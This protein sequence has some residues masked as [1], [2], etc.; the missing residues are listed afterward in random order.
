MVHIGRHIIDPQTGLCEIC[1]RG[2]IHQFRQSK[3]GKQFLYSNQDGKFT[4]RPND[5]EIYH[6]DET[7]RHVRKPLYPEP[8]PPRPRPVVHEPPPPRQRAVVHEQPVVTQRRIARRD[9]SPLDDIH[10]HS[11]NRL[12]TLYY[13]NN[14]GQMA[15]RPHDVPNEPSRRYLVQEH[16]S[17]PTKPAHVE[18]RRA[19]T[20]PPP[21]SDS[22]RSPPRRQNNSDTRVI[23]RQHRDIPND[24]YYHQS[25]R[26]AEM[27]FVEAPHSNNHFSTLRPSVHPS[28][29]DNTPSPR[30]VHQG[31]PNRKHHLEPIQRIH[32]AEVEPASTRRANKKLSPR[33]HEPLQEE[34]IPNGSHARPVRKIEKIYPTPRQYESSPQLTNKH[35][36]STLSN[37]N[38]SIYYIPS[39][40]EY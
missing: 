10:Q 37:K 26:R 33:N 35:V 29:I 24:A 27:Y 31:D 3:H 39:V 1:D 23:E 19:R 12:A 25:P 28:H 2:A 40:N 18:R 36:R 5:D 15:P 17:P 8:P 11:P 34:Y 20:P 30:I 38:P 22:W 4:Y 21:A 9:H 6:K 16:H 7:T 14:T 32:Y 13:V